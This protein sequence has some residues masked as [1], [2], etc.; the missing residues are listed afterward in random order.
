MEMGNQERNY[1]QV[2]SFDDSRDKY[3]SLEAKAKEGEGDE[4]IQYN[5]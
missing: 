2:L 3:L 5:V 4:T 1:A